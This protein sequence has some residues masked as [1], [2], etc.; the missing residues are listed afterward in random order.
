MRISR[1]FLADPLVVGETVDLDK[2]RSHYL[3]HVL[4]LVSGAE[5]ILFNG[6]DGL[7]YNARLTGKGKQLQADILD[8]K[9][10]ATESTLSSHIIQGLGR[11]DHM[12]IMIQKTTELGVNRITL[13][14]AARTQSRL[15]P[16][17]LEKK[18]QHW[19][20]VAISACE[21]CGR[22]RIP[23]IE[24]HP[25]L[26]QAIQ[27]DLAEQKYLLEFNATPFASQLTKK[28]GSVSVLLGPEGGL[29][30]QEIE[31]AVSQSYEKASLGP[32]TLRTE[33]AAISAMVL[34]QAKV[35][36]LI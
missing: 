10:V 1:V 22:S 8:A 33:T 13:F 34:I 25:G 19:K 11:S 23:A 3:T 20:A 35:G 30:P 15:K 5:L 16:S 36:D 6:Q 9:P 21:Q 32:R 2:S 18:R 17:Q 24:F 4:R 26:D 14:N 28:R 31:I 7:D 27:A 29:N 12:D